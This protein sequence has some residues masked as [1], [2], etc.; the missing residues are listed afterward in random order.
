MKTLKFFLATA[1]LLFSSN[2]HAQCGWDYADLQQN[3]KE[4]SYSS[5]D[6]AVVIASISLLEAAIY[7]PNY[8]EKC[9]EGFENNP[10]AS[11]IRKSGLFGDQTQKICDEVGIPY[12]L[13]I[14]KERYLKHLEEEVEKIEFL[15][16]ELI[17]SQLETKKQ[18]DGLKAATDFL[19]NIEVIKASNL[20]SELCEPIIQKL[21]RS[22]TISTES[23][24]KVEADYLR[25]INLREECLKVI[26]G[27]HDKPEP[28]ASVDS[29]KEF[30]NCNEKE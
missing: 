22:K 11:S 18:F 26:L 14:V 12:F 6:N 25:C 27:E 4:Y 20:S 3:W 16:Q 24:A 8:T 28:V 7:N 15:S 23:V 10:L 21:L 19:K 13:N 2:T 5:F 30:C 29:Y 9:W 17:A 1:I